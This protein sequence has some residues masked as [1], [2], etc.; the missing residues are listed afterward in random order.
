MSDTTDSSATPA[1]TETADSHFQMPISGK[2]RKSSK[3]SRPTKCNRSKRFEPQTPGSILG[4]YCLPD[5]LWF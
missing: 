3:A 4:K 5:S 1:S 2:I